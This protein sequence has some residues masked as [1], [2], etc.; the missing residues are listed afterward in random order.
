MF[1]KVKEHVLGGLFFFQFRSFLESLGSASVFLGSLSFHSFS[2][3]A[4]QDTA[5]LRTRVRP[6]GGVPE[7]R[8][9]LDSGVRSKGR[10]GSQLRWCWSG[11]T[12]IVR[13]GALLEHAVERVGGRGRIVGVRKF[14]D[15]LYAAAKSG[16]HRDDVDLLALR[17]VEIH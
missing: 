4:D 14:G 2:V 15:E 3:L 5:L 6:S 12:S 8:G 9:K 1:V 16:V 13:P 11:G 7:G 17:I 10:I